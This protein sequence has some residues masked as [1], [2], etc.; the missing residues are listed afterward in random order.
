[1][2]RGEHTDIE[3]GSQ[4]VVDELPPPILCCCEIKTDEMKNE[5]HVIEHCL[6]CAEMDDILNDCICNCSGNFLRIFDVMEKKSAL[7]FPGGARP[8]SLDAV[9]FICVLPFT[10]YTLYITHGHAYF[11]ML[12][13]SAILMICLIPYVLWRKAKMG[14]RKKVFK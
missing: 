8:I 12:F 13:L 11:Q 3:R 5:K 10:F 2:N 1:M 6:D 14:K 4:K 9:C 7:P